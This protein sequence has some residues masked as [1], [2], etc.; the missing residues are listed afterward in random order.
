MLKLIHLTLVLLVASCSNKEIKMTT[1][2]KKALKT[3]ES[4]SIEIAQESAKIQKTLDLFKSSFGS[5]KQDE[6]PKVVEKI[7]MK[8]NQYY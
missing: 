2:V 1:L 5:Y 6:L 4:K 8:V 3:S 7:K